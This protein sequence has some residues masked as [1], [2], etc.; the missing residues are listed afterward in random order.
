M[1]VAG[2]GCIAVGV[3]QTQ[4]LTEREIMH[5]TTDLVKSKALSKLSGCNVWLK[6][7]N[8]QTSGSFK[9]RGVSLLCKKVIIR[10]IVYLLL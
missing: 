2:R 9:Y 3:S 5:V 10:F 7:E 6:M 1:G 8:Q 4:P